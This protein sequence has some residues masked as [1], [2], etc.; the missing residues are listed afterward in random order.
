VGKNLP[1]RTLWQT[2]KKS[3][4]GGVPPRK[5][6]REGW[7]L[8]WAAAQRRYGELSLLWQETLEQVK[9]MGVIGDKRPHPAWIALRQ[10]SQQMLALEK[11]CDKQ[12]DDGEDGAVE[13]Y[14]HPSVK[15]K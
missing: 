12:L 13:D 11:L 4:S 9:K 1:N 6:K 15:K 8:S 14:I 3:P 10:I 7:K 2:A 5:Q